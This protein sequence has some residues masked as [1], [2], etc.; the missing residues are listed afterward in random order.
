MEDS[1]LRLKGIIKEKQAN[2]W[3]WRGTNPYRR[4]PLEI[5]SLDKQ[6]RA[7]HN[8]ISGKAKTLEDRR[9]V[10]QQNRKEAESADAKLAIND[11][12]PSRAKDLLTHPVTRV[13]CEL[14]R[15]PPV[16]I[17]KEELSELKRLAD[18][19]KSE[20]ELPWPEAVACSWKSIANN[21]LKHLA[22]DEDPDCQIEVSVDFGDGPELGRHSFTGI[23]FSPRLRKEAIHVAQTTP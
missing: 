13:I 16:E 8:E 9:R 1:K 11:M 20:V 4:H 7:G 17:S 5:L 15:V 19:F 23:S 21:L 3:E 18:V 12:T 2:L 6:E 14:M 10:E 22:E